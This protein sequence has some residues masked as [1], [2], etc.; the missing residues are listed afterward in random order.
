MADIKEKKETCSECKGTG[1]IV[2]VCYE[3]NKKLSCEDKCW[4][5]NGTG[6]KSNPDQ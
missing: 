5:C 4:K 2:Y 3:D 6:L 1:W